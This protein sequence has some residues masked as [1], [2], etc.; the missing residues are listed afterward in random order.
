[1]TF[2][3]VYELLRNYRTPAGEQVLFLLARDT[4]QSIYDCVLQSGAR[5][6]LE[7]GTGY[8]ATTCVIAAALD[9]LGGGRVSTIDML[10]REP[11]GIDVLAVHTGLS[12][13][14]EV[15]S[16]NAG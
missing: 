8:G 10:V 5:E 12:R 7:L 11:I 2:D 1:M 15:V 3:N 16:D 13:Y 4:M 14:I 9:E 6:C